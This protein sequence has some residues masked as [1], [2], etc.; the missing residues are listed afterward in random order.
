MT[1]NELRSRYAGLNKEQ[2]QELDK[3]EKEIA[4]KF[5][6]K[7]KELFREAGEKVSLDAELEDAYYDHFP[8]RLEPLPPDAKLVEYG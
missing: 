3:M 4:G 7:A 5:R 2:D 8:S 6:L 1:P